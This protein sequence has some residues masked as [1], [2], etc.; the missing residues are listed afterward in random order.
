MNKKKKK[1]KT[2]VFQPLTWKR[3][4][5]YAGTKY[6]ESVSCS[7]VSD[8]VGP[9]SPPGSSVHGILHARI[10]E[11]VA[12]LF[13]RGSSWP[14]DRTQVSHTANRSLL[15][16]QRSPCWNQSLSIIYFL[17]MVY[18]SLQLLNT[19]FREEEDPIYRDLEIRRLLE[20]VFIFNNEVWYSCLRFFKTYK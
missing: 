20:L 7:V 18:I 1:K 12:V 11:C 15:N 2:L 3:C 17:R 16:H 6:C 14:R 4:F 9:R 10:L 8:S 5:S 19:F 13:S